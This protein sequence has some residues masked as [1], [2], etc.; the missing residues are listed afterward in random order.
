MG[1]PALHIESSHEHKIMVFSTAKFNIDL[2]VSGGP[3][4]VVCEV[5]F[6]HRKE[7]FDVSAHRG[8]ILSCVAI[9]LWARCPPR[10]LVVLDFIIHKA[11]AGDTEEKHV[12]SRAPPSCPISSGVA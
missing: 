1:T 4:A 3:T 11:M 12:S 8:H 10:Y 5:F 9:R 7:A 6:A 2:S